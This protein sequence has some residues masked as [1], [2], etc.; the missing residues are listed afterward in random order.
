[1]YLN[2]IEQFYVTPFSHGLHLRIKSQVSCIAMPTVYAWRQGL[3]VLSDFFFLLMP[4]D[5]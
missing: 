4:V 1:M 2:H 5:L 3:F